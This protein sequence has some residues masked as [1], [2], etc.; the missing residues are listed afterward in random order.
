[1]KKVIISLI[2]IAC[3]TFV[4]ALNVLT[5]AGEI[6]IALDT[7][8][9]IEKSGT[10][11]WS[12]T[13]SDYLIANGMKVK[14]YPDKALGTED[15]KLDQVCQGLLEISNS[16]LSNV[17][18]LDPTINGFLLPYLFDSYEHL[19]RAI[20]NTDI[21]SK[22]NAGTT[23]KGVRVLAIVG[24]GGFDGLLN[25][26]KTIKTPADMKNLRM[27][28]MDKRQAMWFKAWGA[29]SVIVPWS[30]IYSALQ[31]GV[32]DGYINAPIVPIM[33][34]H[35]EVVKYFTYNKAGLPIRA[36]ICSDDWYKGLSKKE[37]TIIDEGVMKATKA[38]LVWQAKI[39]VSG[40]EALKKAGVEVYMPTFEEREA[41]AKLLRPIYGKLSSPVIAKMFLK[42]ASATK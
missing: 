41:F 17:S 20:T 28:A 9:D 33:F 38:N 35:T 27:R 31:T 39:E 14:L 19:N 24:V 15:E 21:M 10:Y 4:S 12:K 5:Y 18:Q 36:I 6:K 8:P 26:K 13:F 34:K 2:I 3:V 30:E 1:M 11:V 16:N 32:A 42:A 23:K 22:I 37:R 25:S 7:P 29:S 40:I